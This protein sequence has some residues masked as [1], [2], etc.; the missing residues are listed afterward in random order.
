MTSFSTFLRARRESLG[1]RPY[2]TARLLKV[3]YHCLYSW[4]VGRTLP[5][6]RSL[7]RLAKVMKVDQAVV[8]GL[9]DESRN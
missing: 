6:R 8:Q 5:R 9:I 2:E 1:L 4:E 3:T 7:P